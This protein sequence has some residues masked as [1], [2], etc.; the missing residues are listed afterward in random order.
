MCGAG[1]DTVYGFTDKKVVEDREYYYRVTAIN[2]AGP[3]MPCDHNRQAVK[4]QAKPGTF[5]T[6]YS[7]E[8]NALLVAPWLDPNNMRDQKL[9]VGEML[10]YDLPIA[11][12]P[13]PE[14]SWFVNDKPLK[15]THKVKI[16]TDK[17]RTILRVTLLPF[18]IVQ[19][20]Y[21][22]SDRQR[23]AQ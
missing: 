1:L 6:V 8:K 5:L 2:K 10:K 23:A 4:C 14:V 20:V 22:R 17:T 16:S 19:K 21:L 18:K 7:V 3:G 12:E 15:I 9:K 13:T 11:G